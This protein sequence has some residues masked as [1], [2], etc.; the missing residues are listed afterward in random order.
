MAFLEIKNVSIV[1]MSACVPSDILK[2]EDIYKWD[3][4]NTFIETTGI[5][6]KHCAP[7]NVTASDLCVKA[8]ERL[9][10]ELNWN[11]N[12]INAV[13]FVSQTPDYILP[14]TAPIIQNRLGLSC[15]C[16][17]LDIS[18]GCSGWVYGLS[19]IAAL[20]Q[21]GYI[22][23]GLL[24]AGDSVLKL[25]SP[26]DKSTYPIFGDAG[27]ATALQ[28]NPQT[29]GLKF[30]MHADGEGYKDIIVSDGGTR[31]SISL[32]SLNER[33]IGNDI[34]R[35]KMNIEMDG[36]SVFSFGISKVPKI[37][38][39]LL[40]KFELNKESIDLFCFHQ[41]NLMMNEKIRKKLKLPIEKVPYS[42]SEFGNTSCASIPLTLVSKCRNKLTTNYIK[43]I[44]C[45]FGVGLS[46][47]AVYYETNRIV[48]PEI[49]V[50]TNEQ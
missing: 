19:V 10:E 7:S 17:T 3:G 8:A 5:R 47:G 50:Y 21:N 2:T 45:G 39:E 20:M 9:I 25:C 22:N 38:N 12:D 16:F 15:D 43:H 23:K 41:A 49:I 14:S 30:V 26:H 4:C 37:I 36:M 31:N 35:S 32:D 29:N 24:L 28:Y 44:D 46:W 13:I 18:L 40:D 1:G 6:Q 48:C 42:I 34:I 27:S 11:K 33:T